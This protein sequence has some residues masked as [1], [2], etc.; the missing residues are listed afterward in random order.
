MKV[1][2]LHKYTPKQLWSPTPTPTIPHQ[3]TKKSKMTPELSQNQKSELK[4]T[5][6]IKGVRLQ[7]YNQKQV[8]NPTPTPKIAHQGRKSQ[9]LP[10]KKSKSKVRIEVTIENKS[11]SITG[12][13]PKISF[14]PYPDPKNSP[15]GSQIVPNYPKVRSKS[16]VR[17]EENVKNKSFFF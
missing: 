3:G 6:K 12:T 7:E 9:K 8:L 1:C 14:E 16:K 15:L 11:C 4:K 13:D 17:I 10:Q 2:Q 5:Q